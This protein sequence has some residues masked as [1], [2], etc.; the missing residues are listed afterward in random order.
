MQGQVVSADTSQSVAPYVCIEP[1]CSHPGVEGITPD[2][3]TKADLLCLA[4]GEQY[5][6]HWSITIT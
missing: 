2:F 6:N 3:E 4:A 1:W 5:K